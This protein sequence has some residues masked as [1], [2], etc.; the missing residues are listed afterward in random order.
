MGGLVDD[1]GTAGALREIARDRG[2]R[3]RERG[4]PVVWRAVRGGGRRHGSH[5][6]VPI[7]T[8]RCLLR[9]SGPVSYLVV[10]GLPASPPRISLVPPHDPA[11]PPASTAAV[12][13]PAF[14]PP[15]PFRRRPRRRRYGRIRRGR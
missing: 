8:F 10:A 7:T 15:E 11:E 3:Y 12:D 6:D 4:G 1:P 9:G 13:A 5:R 2:R 14:P